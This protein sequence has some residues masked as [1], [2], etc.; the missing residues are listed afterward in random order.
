MRLTPVS[1]W[2]PEQ[3]REGKGGSEETK[4]T[5]G[6]LGFKTSRSCGF[7]SSGPGLSF[8]CSGGF[9]VELPRILLPSETISSPQLHSHANEAL[10]GLD[11]PGILLLPSDPGCPSAQA[12][13]GEGEHTLTK[14]APG[15]S[16]QHPSFTD[17][18]PEGQRS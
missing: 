15:F 2:G 7:S 14:R 4:G 6:A 17:E 11:L 10:T 3:G 1:L 16:R 8:Q 13:A 12:A 5:V 9:D 18:E